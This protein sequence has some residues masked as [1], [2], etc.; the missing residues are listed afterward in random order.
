MNLKIRIST[1]NICSVTVASA[2]LVIAGLATAEDTKPT[3]TS[4]APVS[5]GIS[6]ERTERVQKEM[7]ALKKEMQ[8]SLKKEQT[9]MRDL[10]EK[11]KMAQ[12]ERFRQESQKRQAAETADKKNTD[13]ANAKKH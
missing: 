6:K 11:E 4:P 13:D 7:Q 3:S 1:I 12:L 10:R 9:E 8:A 2:F 5:G